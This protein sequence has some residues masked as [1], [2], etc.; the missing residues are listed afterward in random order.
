MRIIARTAVAFATSAALITTSVSAV[1]VAAAPIEATM[2]V[3]RSPDRPALLAKLKALPRAHVAIRLL[4][5][6]YDTVARRA[7]IRAEIEAQVARVEKRPPKF[8]GA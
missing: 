2:H 5:P 8:Q 4:P 3:H 1:P 7:V 6:P